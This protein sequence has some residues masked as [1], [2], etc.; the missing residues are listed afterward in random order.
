MS[1]PTK[2]G[3]SKVKKATPQKKVKATGAVM[4]GSTMAM[5]GLAL[6]LF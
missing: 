2:W 1:V 4:L 3:E 5:A 6:N